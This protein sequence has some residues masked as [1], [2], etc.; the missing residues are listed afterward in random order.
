MQGSVR[1]SVGF[2]SLTVRDFFAGLE[3]PSFV[4]TGAVQE[5]RSW[6]LLTVRDMFARLGDASGARLDA[7]EA[8]QSLPRSTKPCSNPSP[9]TARALVDFAWGE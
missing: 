5:K 3:A 1:A 9:R 7:A 4:T 8:A 6:P 2:A